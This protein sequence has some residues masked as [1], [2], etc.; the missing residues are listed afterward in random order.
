MFP[1]L[2]PPT[3]RRDAGFT[4]LEVLIALA[5]VAVSVLAI[6]SVMSTNARGVRTLESH[7]A[8]MQAAQTVLAT[9]IPERNELTPGVRSGQLR[10]YRWQID[11]GPVGG[12][13]AAADTDA[14]W[15]PELVKIRVRSPSGAAVDL[16]TV[17]LVHGPGRS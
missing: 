15:I 6:G 8:L 4:I 14:A 13:W 12:G 5:I 10:G 2:Q 3:D 9:A 17:R 16:E 11:V 7:V 1:V